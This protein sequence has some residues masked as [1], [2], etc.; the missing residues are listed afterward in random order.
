ME[1]GLKT[2][3]NVHTSCDPSNGNGENRPHALIPK[4]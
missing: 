2:V 1:F 4:D 3:R